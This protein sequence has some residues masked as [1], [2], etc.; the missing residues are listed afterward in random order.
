MCVSVVVLKLIKATNHNLTSDS[1]PALY[2]CS[3]S[4]DVTP[5]ESFIR[6]GDAVDRH[7]SCRA[8]PDQKSI[9]IEISSEITGNSFLRSAAQSDVI[10]LHHRKNRTLQDHITTWQTIVYMIIINVSCVM[11][12][13]RMM[14]TYQSQRC[15]HCC[16]SLLLQ[17]HTST[18][19]CLMGRRLQSSRRIS[20]FHHRS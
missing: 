13:L 15:W 3:S 5:V 11:C 2:R 1:Q 7:V 6:S 19:Q 16:C 4:R 8:A 18:L 10:S 20:L 9:F 12:W 17:T 14:L